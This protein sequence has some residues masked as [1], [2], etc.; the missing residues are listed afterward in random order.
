[1]YLTYVVRRVIFEYLALGLTLNHGKTKSGPTNSE[2]LDYGVR[3]TAQLAVALITYASDK[4][5]PDGAE[6]H[7][8]LVQ[9]KIEPSTG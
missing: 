7:V 4:R 8:D 6:M 1:M 3:K 5:I 2:A 9:A